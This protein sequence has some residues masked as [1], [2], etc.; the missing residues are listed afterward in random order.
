MLFWR[1]K[2][3][4]LHKLRGLS[5]IVFAFLVVTF[6]LTGCG[7]EAKRIPKEP[8]VVKA[9]RAID[10]TQKMRTQAVSPKVG[11]WAVIIGI[12]DYKY[13]TRWD[14]R[15]GL[16][17]LQFADRDAKAF[18]EFLMSPQGGAFQ[19]GHVLLLTNK[20]ATVNEVRNAIGGFLAK[21]LED[22]LVIIFYA[23][24]GV[25]D[26]ENPENL[27]LACYDTV[28]GKY[29]GT[30]FPMWGIDD[31]LRRTIHSKRV[32]V[33][34]DACHSAGVG[35]ARGKSVSKKFNDYMDRLAASK[36]GVTKITAS[37]ADELSLEKDYLGGGHGVFTYYLLEALRGEADD[38]KDGF[39]TMVEAYDYLY[40]K[41]RSETHHSQK[42]W[43]SGYV[44]SDIPLGIVDSQVLAAIVGRAKSQKQKTVQAAAPYRLTPVTIDLPKDSKVA[45]KLARAKLAKD[46]PGVAEEMVEEILKRN[47]STKPDALA[48][49]IEILLQD[50][51]LKE[52]EDAEDRL[53]IPYPKHPAAKKG[54]RFV[55]NYYLKETE[56]TDT[57]GQIRRIETYLKR[58]PGGLLE[59]EAK[60][61]IEDIR[62]GVR[63]R[64]EKEFQ[65]SLILARGFV[66]QNRFDRARE[67][68]NSAQERAQEALSN[69]GVTL[70][71]KRITSLRLQAQAKEREYRDR[72]FREL[73]AKA[74]DQLA[75]GYYSTG[76][77]SLEKAREFATNT[78]L[79]EADKLALQ[80]NAP[81]KVQ[82][83][84]ES[85]PF[86][87]NIPIT[88]RYDATDKEGDPIR[89]VSWDF[90]D[91]TSVRENSPQ[92]S[93]AK[94]D[95]PQ[96]E[97]QYVVTLK[98]TDGHTTV[99]T[100]KNLT[101]KRQDCV[102]RDGPFCALPSGIVKDSNTGLEWVAG[103]DS[104][105]NWNEARSWVEDLNIAGDGWRMPTVD[106]L[107]GLYKMEAG[108]WNMTPLLKTTG[109]WM[110]SGETKGSSG[111][112]GFDFSRGAED[113]YHRYNS[114]NTR[115]FAVR[116]RGDG[117]Q[118]D[119]IQASIKKISADSRPSSTSD[120]LQRDGIYVAYPNGIVK[121]T[122]TG[123]EWK[124]GPD[125][126]TTLDEAEP[127]VQNLNLDGGG[128]R[129]PTTDELKTLY[130]KG[131]GNRNMTRFLKTT[132]W[133]VWSGE[134]RKNRWGSREAWRLDFHS[135][136]KNCIIGLFS[137][138]VRAFAVRSR[139]GG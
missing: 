5:T 38:N 15:K 91:G 32:F 23:G 89:V 80:Y 119:Q 21:S 128:W 122:N 53:V 94:W 41:V 28:P 17:D 87:W 114:N 12:S 81:P 103:P 98:A 2:N 40:D 127:W 132:G 102:A 70:D 117:S 57:E 76:H 18:A 51:D 111:A 126:N 93:Y 136:Y 4:M 107:K 59:K 16:P 8:P 133:W 3:N 121:D 118:P 34:A 113:W 39:V 135:G 82:I 137:D 24:H 30:A 35:G 116:S 134:I 13:D 27:Y 110:W 97:R 109:W 77:E 120:M 95:G 42:P 139:T 37:R 25:P 108:M 63:M 22:D 106:E 44:S 90:G 67:E 54:A 96:K 68:L 19:P 7:G 84:T 101:V 69:Y 85:G 129:M 112:R 26:P 48:M 74:M 14:R 1:S 52:A 83:V 115:V 131:A 104:D 46:E 88:F 43:A 105:M 10:V 100:R 86:Y 92:H 45:I 62:E 6:W 55:Y 50:G 36:E 56:R 130:K 29:Y 99:T 47:D 20:K 138:D 60:D 61:K 66:S 125:R 49:K 33:F 11:R 31:A 73:F 72:M 9:D 58:H 79:K 78:Q 123:L 124:V 75:A 65:E 71:T 64:Y